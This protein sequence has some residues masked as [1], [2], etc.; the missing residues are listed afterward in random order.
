[1]T[2]QSGK[3]L[4]H[5]AIGIILLFAAIP[6]IFYIK[7]N[8]DDNVLLGAVVS[9]IMAFGVIELGKEDDSPEESEATPNGSD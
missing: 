9:L 1:M 6:I 4:S 3:K 7:H 2:E 8:S 5:V